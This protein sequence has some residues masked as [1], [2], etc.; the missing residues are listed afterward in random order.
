MA[1]NRAYQPILSSTGLLAI[2][3]ADVLIDGSSLG[4]VEDVNFTVT[5][6][7]KDINFGYPERLYSNELNSINA[8]VSM[9]LLELGGPCKTLLSS[10]ASSLNTGVVPEQDLTLE[11][12]K[13]QGNNVNIDMVGTALLQE[14][15]L[16]FSNEFNLCKMKFEQLVP[17]GG[18]ISDQITFTE[19]SAASNSP[20]KMIDKGNISIGV[21][22]AGLYTASQGVRLNLATTYKRIEVGYPR[23]LH[24]LIPHLHSVTLEVDSEEFT[25]A[26]LGELFSVSAPTSI[27][28]EAGLFDGS[29]ITITI[30]AAILVPAAVNVPNNEWAT[31]T[32]KFVATGNTLLT[33]A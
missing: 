21:P 33:I 32:K 20:S 4:V 19:G 7:L 8:Q 3:C 22:L 1:F 25:T 14:F 15:D 30:P 28:V 11:V 31:I 6:T 24:Q 9:S 17:N 23:T 29:V 2:S 18:A 27:T 12:F 5:P 16:S 26:S 10:I 13:P